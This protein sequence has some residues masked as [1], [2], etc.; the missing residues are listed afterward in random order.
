MSIA[1]SQKNTCIFE[2]VGRDKTRER[3]SG[4]VQE[5]RTDKRRGEGE[6]YTVEGVKNWKNKT[7]KC[8]KK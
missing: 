6:V 3:Q 5:R 7:G 1:Q 8:R 4:L 2:K